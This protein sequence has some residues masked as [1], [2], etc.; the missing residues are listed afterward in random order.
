[1]LGVGSVVMQLVWMPHREPPPPGASARDILRNLHP[2]LRRLLLAEIFTR[3]CDWLV[4]EFVVLYVVVVRAVP[5][6]EVGVLIAV[7]NVTALMTYLP[8]GRLTERAGLQPFI[9]LT[10]IFFA[11][12]PL[13]LSVVPDG[14]WLYAAFAVYGLREIGEPARKALITSLVPEEVRARGVGLYW[15]LRTFAIC[16]ASLAGA[17]IWWLA[18]PQALLQTA[19]VF[20]CAGAATYYLLCRN[21]RLADS[22]VL[23][24]PR[25]SA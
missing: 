18:G 15:G 4:R 23:P 13:V 1:V 5:I 17:G 12:F 25:A 21:P 16:W 20:G 9:G 24:G 3:W 11:L 2:L 14:P 22:P 6:Q 8:I 19:F 7:Q 10:F